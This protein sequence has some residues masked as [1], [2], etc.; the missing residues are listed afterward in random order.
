MQLIN[1]LVSIMIFAIPVILIIGM[2]RFAKQSLKNQ[3][4]ILDKLDELLK[5]QRNK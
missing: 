3:D 1:L 4:Q 2:I 5:S